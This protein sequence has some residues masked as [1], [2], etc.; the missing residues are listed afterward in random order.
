MARLFIAVWPPEELRS[1]LSG[2]PRKNR[3]G[4]KW[5][6]PENWHV[7]LRFLGEADPD[8]VARHLDE[9]ELSP[10]AVRYGPA[11]DVFMERVIMVPAHGLDALAATVA[12]STA[13]LGTEPPRNRFSGHLTLARLKARA[14]IPDVIGALIGADDVV[15]EIALVESRLRP[16][17]PEYET[18]A[19]W[20]A[21]R[22]NF[23]DEARIA[24]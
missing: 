10:A 3:P 1:D 17:G 8:E 16:S 22:G 2:L 19:T 18:L 12:R 7:T 5:V 24:R 15:D 14:R 6:E 13:D 21:S 23:G 20:T 9:V 11:I 4:I